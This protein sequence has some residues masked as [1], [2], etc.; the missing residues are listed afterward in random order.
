MKL[1]ALFIL[2]A[3]AAGLA[4][5][6]AQGPLPG[7]AAITAGLQQAFGVEPVWAFWLTDSAKAPLLWA[8]L[9]LAIAL[10]WV[11]VGLR[12]ALAVSLAYALAFAADK[13]LRMAIFVPR[14]SEPLVAVAEPAT[15]SGL[16]STFGLVYAAMFGVALLAFPPSR[17]AWFA[18][19]A[20]AGLLII[21]CVSRVVLG[22]HWP[23]QMF[24]SAMLG[25]AL[26][27][28]AFGLISKFRRSA[29]ESEGKTHRHGRRDRR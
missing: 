19:P 14:P 6:L 26:A 3:C 12:G 22:G 21:G 27:L 20:A 11:A 17:S 15:S 7:D 2:A 28:L 8:T 23:S 24:A 29:L 9:F 25:L 18:R 4:L 16:P 13:A 1:P 5:V 10:A